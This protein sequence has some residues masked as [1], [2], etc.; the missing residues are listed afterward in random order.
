MADT[1]VRALLPSGLA[2]LALKL[3]EPGSAIVANTGGDALT[4]VGTSRLYEATVTEALSG[5][6][7]AA[8]ETATGSVI[9]GGYV[10]LADDAG[11][12]DVDRGASQ[13]SVDANGT[14]IAAVKAKTDL[15]TPGGVNVV[16]PVASGGRITITHSFDYSSDGGSAEITIHEA[17]VDDWDAAK[18]AA[19]SYALYGR[20]ST[21]DDVSFQVDATLNAADGD[22]LRSFTFNVLQSD[23]PSVGAYKWH[24]FGTFTATSRDVEI[25][26]GVIRAERGR[27]VA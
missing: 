1:I 4:E 11:P 6:Y 5:S 3:Y 18:L 10:T 16:S 20:H 24:L 12:Y 21:E 26:N 2:G 17:A 19:D 22:G 15:I 14:A 8:V 7:V 13:A 9:G 23:V 25:A 27:I